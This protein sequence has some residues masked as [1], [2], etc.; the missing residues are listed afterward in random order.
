MNKFWRWIS[1]PFMIFR[2]RRKTDFVAPRAGAWI[3]TPTN[4][5]HVE[6]KNEQEP[7]AQLHLI[8]SY[9]TKKSTIG[10]LF[11]NRQF[12]CWILEDPI[13]KTKIPKITAIPEGT[14]HI[15]LTRSPRFNK[16]TP[17]LLRVPGFEG[18]RIHPGNTPEH[19]DGCLLPGQARETDFVGLSRIAFD[20]LVSKIKFI[21]N[22]EKVFIKIENSQDRMET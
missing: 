7:V 19:T 2:R 4:T 17:E 9:F 11:I 22:K 20:N 3:E 10:K 5:P 18:I 6:I 13:R 12:E 21:L 14:Y 15:A 1:N 16:I 8:R